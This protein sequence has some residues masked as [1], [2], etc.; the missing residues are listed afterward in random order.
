MSFAIVCHGCGAR[1]AVADDY[2]RN[3]MRCPE[4]GVMCPLPPRP[5]AEKKAEERPPAEDAARIEDEEPAAAARPAPPPP[6]TTFLKEPAPAGKALATCPHCGEMVRA[7]ARK[8]GRP[9][10]CPICGAAWAAA[11]A[12]PKPALPPLPVPPPPD[13]FAGSTPDEDPDSGNPY[14]TADAGARRCPGCTDLLGPEVVVCVRCGF[15]LRTGRKTVKEYQRFER[16]W[17]SGMPLRTRL[18]LFAVCQAFALIAMGTGFLTLNDSPST[19]AT[20]FILSWIV[21]TA[22][23]AFLLGSFDH[24]DLKRY[25]SGRVDLTRTWRVGFILWPPRKIDVRDY[26]GVSNGVMAYAGLWEWFVFLILLTSGILPALLYWYCAIHKTEYTVS[27]TDVHGH[28]EVYVYR[29][30]SEEQMHEIKQT[31]RDAMTV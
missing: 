23:M 19:G 8:R 10:K 7:P 16:S 26:G 17:D 5:A 27:L 22:M 14:R 12:P 11:A 2:P 29:G 21:Y 28:S 15:D 24:F 1:L 20:T 31:L 18:V 30:W 25:K 4:C 3:K 9:G 13:E 6:V